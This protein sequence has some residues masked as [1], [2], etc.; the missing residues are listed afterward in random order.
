MLYFTIE[1][2]DLLFLLLYAFSAQ[3]SNDIDFIPCK[4][5]STVNYPQKILWEKSFEKSH[6]IMV[7]YHIVTLSNLISMTSVTRETSAVR[8]KLFFLVFYL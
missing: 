7:N 1:C 3:L 4:I 6:F 8:I 5:T 2:Y